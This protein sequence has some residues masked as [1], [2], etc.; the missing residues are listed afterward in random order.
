MSKLGKIFLWAA[1]VGALAAVAAG[2]MLTMQ[3]TTTRATLAQTEQD[4]DAAKQAAKKSDA[5]AKAAEAA[6]ADSDAKLTTA[7]GQI[8]DLTTQLASAQKDESDAKTAVAAANDKATQA[9]AA[10]DD[11][12]KTLNGHTAQELQD[13]TAK[14]QSD[15]AASQA[16]QKILQDQLQAST[17]QVASL[18]DSLRRSKTG[19]MP[20]IAGKVTFV[21]HTWNFVVLNIGQTDGV[22]PNGELI[23]YRGRDFLGKVRVTKVDS[24]DAVAEILPDIKGDI[25]IGDTVV[26]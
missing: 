4:R 23:I 11:I 10:L 16:E 7:T 2:V 18:Q 15:L 26:N 22:V 17:Q 1:L 5:E 25:Q 13:A 19:D 9:Q 21:D 6:K 3:F 14:A 8:T 24:N 12:N 20:P